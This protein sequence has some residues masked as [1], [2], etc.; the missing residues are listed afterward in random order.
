MSTIRNGY[1][2]M[3]VFQKSLTGH[4]KGGAGA[5][6][7][8]GALQAPITGIIPG[9]RQHRQ[10]IAQIWNHD[11]PQQHHKRTLLK[12]GFGH[13]MGIRIEWRA[14]HR[15]APPLRFRDIGA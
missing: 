4:P 11:V 2:V 12:R 3:G 6:M 8:N 14:S 9:N 7:V 15:D 13:L 5:W 1:P 10:C